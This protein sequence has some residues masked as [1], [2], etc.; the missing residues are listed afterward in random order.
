VWWSLCFFTTFPLLG[1]FGFY[2]ATHGAGMNAKLGLALMAVT[3]AWIV[4]LF[5]LP[6]AW[7]VAERL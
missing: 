6:I 2:L 3:L 1:L 7:I 4:Y 5:F